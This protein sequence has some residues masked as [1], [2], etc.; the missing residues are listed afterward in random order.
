MAQVAIN[1][2]NRV[3]SI[4]I[5]CSV[6]LLFMSAPYAVA[7]FSSSNMPPFDLGMFVMP[8]QL[9][10][11]FYINYLWLIN[12][13]LFKKRILLFLLINIALV[14]CFMFVSEA[15]RELRRPPQLPL[16]EFKPEIERGLIN[17]HT[18]LAMVVQFLIIGFSVAIKMTSNWYAAREQLHEVQRQNTEAELQQLKSQLNPHFLFNSLN[19]IYALIEF[20]SQKAQT[21]LTNLC[22]MLR[23]QLYESNRTTI[24]LEKEIEFVSSYCELMKLRLTCSTTLKLEFPND[25]PKIEIAPLLFIT[26]VENAFK[27]G[28]SATSP[29][30][31]H[32]SI[33]HTTKDVKCVVE[34][35]NFPKQDNDRS[36][37]GIGIDNLKR[38][39]ELLYPHKHI[40]TTE[41]TNNSYIATLIINC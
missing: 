16:K 31:I 34:N 26:L 9:I 5:H 12:K 8:V 10:I 3:V 35:S 32:I 14:I 1:S 29:S 19:N 11:L 21:S 24:P 27:H 6:W 2:K 41:L 18:A 7:L 20:D 4:V 25:N 22:D 40:F 39:L 33:S 38:R 28:I 17:I 36:G 30:W 13:M 23:Y 37:S 15:L